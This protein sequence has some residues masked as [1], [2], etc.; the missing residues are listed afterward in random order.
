MGR[1]EVPAYEAKLRTLD[2]C[3]WNLESQTETSL[4]QAA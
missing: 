2:E 4:R 1:I 3:F